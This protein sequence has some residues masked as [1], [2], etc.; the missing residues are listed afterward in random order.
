MS[1]LGGVASSPLHELS[2]NLAPQPVQV[3]R[4]LLASTGASEAAGR[5]VSV[6]GPHGGKPVGVV[7]GDN[8]FPLIVYGFVSGFH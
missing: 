3:V 1:R 4:A 6:W 8:D 2:G 7:T 5:E